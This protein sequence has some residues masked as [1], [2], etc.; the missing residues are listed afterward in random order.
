MADL[1]QWA[2]VFPV[3]QVAVHR[4]SVPATCNGQM[5]WVTYTG[6]QLLFTC[7]DLLHVGE[8]LLNINRWLGE[9]QT[10]ASIAL[11]SGAHRPKECDLRR[12]QT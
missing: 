10:V 4:V 12:Y 3:P 1:R 8:P 11:N 7:L 9:L 2:A 5:T 6:R